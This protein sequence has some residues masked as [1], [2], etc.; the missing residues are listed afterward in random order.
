MIYS[1]TAFAHL[2]IKKEWGNAVWEIR[3]VNQRFLETYFRLPEQFRNLEM[4]LRERLRASLTRGKVE[5]SL[6]IE[7]S[8]N[9]N[10]ELAL[11]KAYAEKVISSLQTLRGIAGEGEINLVDILRYPGVV[12][13]QTQDLDQIGQDLLAGFEQILADFIA[14]RGREGANLQALI[15]QRLDTIAEIATKVQAQMPEIL[16]WQKDKLQQRFDELNLQLDPQRLEQEMVLT[17][18]RVDVA[19]EL[20]RLQLHV[21]ETTNVLKKGG[22]VGRKLDFMMQELNRESNTLASKSINADVTNSAVELKVLIEQ[23][24]EQIQ[25]L[26]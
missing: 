24:R 6:R 2:E 5:C 8:N 3:S 4:T 13:A 15:Q 25:N 1:M 26:E 12:D 10:S 14:M 7:L 17:A 19:E 16:Q 20:D 23:M 21:K 22:A 18:Q 9:Q 11:N